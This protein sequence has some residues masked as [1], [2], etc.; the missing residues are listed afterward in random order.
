MTA[1]KRTAAGQH[2]VLE[3]PVCLSEQLTESDVVRP[4]NCAHLVCSDCDAKLHQRTDLRCPTCRSPREGYT[5][6][7]ADLQ[8]RI[9]HAGDRDAAD[10]ELANEIDGGDP[11]LAIMQLLG[12]A[13]SDTNSQVQAMDLGGGRLVIFPMGANA[14]GNGMRGAA[15]VA[16]AEPPV[17]DLYYDPGTGAFTPPRP[18]NATRSPVVPRA[19]RRQSMSDDA[20]RYRSIGPDNDVAYNLA[21]PVP[22]RRLSVTYMTNER[23]RELHGT[24][25]AARQ[26]FNNLSHVDIQGFRRLISTD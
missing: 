17:P 12:I 20:P 24:A 4:F 3:C 10:F 7:D 2:R 18:P 15:A 5:T 23:L 19:P 1:H 21:S 14:A 8:A 13:R 6:S 9:N 16:A 11:R 25:D 22:R 26:A